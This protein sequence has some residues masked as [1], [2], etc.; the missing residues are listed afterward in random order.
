MGKSARILKRFL[1]KQ[2]CKALN[3]L[4]CLAPWERHAE[5]SCYR[6][7]QQFEMVARPRFEP[8]KSMALC[9]GSL[10][11]PISSWCA[12]RVGG[13]GNRDA[14]PK[15]S[16]FSGSIDPYRFYDAADTDV[17]VMDQLGLLIGVGIAAAAGEPLRS[18]LK[19]TRFHLLRACL[20]SW[21][22]PFIA[23]PLYPSLIR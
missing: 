12:T 10:R 19:V 6:L 11:P 21:L 17:V 20:C 14:M 7:K 18:D 3:S 8:I 2:F 13:E 5:R 4:A 15:R 9:S 23:S 22:Q 1:T 16:E